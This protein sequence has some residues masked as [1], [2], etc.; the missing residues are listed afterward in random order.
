MPATN[1]QPAIATAR[2]PGHCSSSRPTAR[3]AS[4]CQAWYWT[5]VC[6]T[7]AMSGA[8][9]A[10]SACAPNAPSATAT[11]I[12]TDA[13]NEGEARAHFPWVPF[14]I[15]VPAHQPRQDTNDAHRTPPRRQA[16]VRNRRLHAGRRTARLPRRPG[17]RR[18]Q[19]R[20]HDAGAA[21]ARGDRP[22]AGRSRQRQDAHP[23][24][25]DLPARHGRLSRAE[26]RLGSVGACR[27]RR[28]RARRSKR[29]SRTPTTRSRSRSSPPR[30]PET[31]PKARR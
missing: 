16:P 4:A 30:R 3:S 27:D 2:C 24:G 31:E 12:A 8:S 10:L 13:E 23:V 22:P 26:R 6:Q 29:S 18:P 20:H 5:A 11:N 9:R 28:R 21:G 1:S 17:R 25:D 14:R 15:P 19:G 7:A